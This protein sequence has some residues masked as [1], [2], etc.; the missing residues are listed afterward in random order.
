MKIAGKSVGKTTYFIENKI[1][2]EDIGLRYEGTP[3]VT[4]RNVFP[5]S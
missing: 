4:G 3:I 2:R 5:S 1:K